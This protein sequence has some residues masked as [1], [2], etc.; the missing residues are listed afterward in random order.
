MY[1]LVW[2][3]LNYF[4]LK[5][6]AQIL[7][8]ALFLS[9]KVINQSIV[10]I[11]V[12]AQWCI[13]M[14]TCMCFIKLSPDKT[15]LTLEAWAMHKSCRWIFSST[16]NDRTKMI[17]IELWAWLKHFWIYNKGKKQTK[18]TRWSHKSEAEVITRRRACALLA[19]K[20]SNI[21]SKLNDD[22]CE[23]FLRYSTF[24]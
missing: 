21:I 24:L 22:F 10:Q 12:H 19:L 3:F 1:D 20:T 4:G 6:I 18:K 2:W 11:Q 5:F 16:V 17:K 7:T 15:L 14:Q 9:Q 23:D 13:L 8:Y